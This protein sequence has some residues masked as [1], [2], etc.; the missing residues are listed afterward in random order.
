MSACQQNTLLSSASCPNT[1]YQQWSTLKQSCIPIQ[2][3]ATLTLPDPDYPDQN[4]YILFASDY[5]QGEVF[6]YGQFYETLIY[7]VKGGF[8]NAYFRLNK[9]QDGWHILRTPPRY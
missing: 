9:R 2:K 5:S 4:I 7:P 1:P 6:A 3:E 8:A